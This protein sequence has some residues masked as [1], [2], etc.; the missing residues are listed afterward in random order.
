MGADGRVEELLAQFL[1]GN[2]D[3]ERLHIAIRT[4]GRGA[5]GTA[6]AVG[7]ALHQSRESAGFSQ[8]ELGYL[9]NVD[10][11]FVSRAER[12]VCQPALA[13]VLLLA[14]ALGL[15]AASLVARMEQVLA[16]QEA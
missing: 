10:R 4:L 13:T 15:S 2:F 5:D 7:V 16:Q 6:H 11:T 9:A 3:G 8:E 14:G 12:G 1:A